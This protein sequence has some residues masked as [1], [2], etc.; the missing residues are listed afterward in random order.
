[1]PA[2]T[3]L[4]VTLAGAQTDAAGG[5]VIYLETNPFAEGNYQ[6]LQRSVFSNGLPPT[7]NISCE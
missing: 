3:I 6:S 5:L 1:V 2:Y 4:R 7:K